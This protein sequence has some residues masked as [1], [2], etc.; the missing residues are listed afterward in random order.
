MMIKGWISDAQVKNKL[1]TSDEKW[2][3][4]YEQIMNKSWTIDKENIEQDMLE[5]ET[6]I[7]LR[8]RVLVLVVETKQ[9]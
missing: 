1:W 4:S 7:L 2:W 6:T 5:A 9:K 8:I 3:M